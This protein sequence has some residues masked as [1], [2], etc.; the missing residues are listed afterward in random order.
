MFIIS[1]IIGVFMGLGLIFIIDTIILCCCVSRPTRRKLLGFKDDD[2]VVTW[3]YKGQDGLTKGPF[4]TYTMQQMYLDGQFADETMVRKGLR[5]KWEPISDHFQDLGHSAKI[6]Y[7]EGDN[8]GPYSNEEMREKMDDAEID[9]STQV[10]LSNHVGRYAAVGQFFPDL[11]TAFL[12]APRQPGL[13]G[14]QAQ[15][16]Q[17]VGAEDFFD[18]QALSMRSSQMQGR[19]STHMQKTSTKKSKTGPQWAA[20]SK[21]LTSSCGDGSEDILCKT[22][23]KYAAAGQIRPEDSEA[24]GAERIGADRVGSTPSTDDLTPE[25]K[26]L[27]HVAPGEDADK[28]GSDSDEEGKARGSSDDKGQAENKEPQENFGWDPVTGKRRSRPAQ[29][30]NHQKFGQRASKFGIFPKQIGNF[31]KLDRK[32]DTKVAPHANMFGWSAFGPVPKK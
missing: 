21:S 5:G 17:Q 28:Q 24:G 7:I 26:G 13:Q 1:V 12:C 3:Y 4:D 20:H 31:G 19:T 10:Q 27:R 9:A 6:W 25:E 22:T 14:A 8:G 15:P 2:G 18:M 30:L 11:A 16:V 23:T 32:D 29:P